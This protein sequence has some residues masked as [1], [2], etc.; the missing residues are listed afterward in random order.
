VERAIAGP[1]GTLR[2]TDAGDGTAI[3]GLHGLTASRRYVLMGSRALERRGHRVILYDARGHGS[4]DPPADARYGY[5]QLAEDLLALLDALDLRDALLVGASMGAHTAVRFALEHPQR[6]AGL[7]LVTPAYDPDRFEQALPRWD[8]LAAAL[9]DGGPDGFIEAYDPGRLAPSW[10]ETVERV[11]AQRLAAHQHL[12]AVAD[13][14]AAVPRSR[15]FDALEDLAAIAA[16]TLVVA[17]RDE[18]DP[19]HPLEL[20]RRYADAIAGAELIVEEPNR[21][22]IAWQGGQLS[23][24]IAALAARAAP[25]GEHEPFS[26]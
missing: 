21:S 2:L 9:R 16:P 10:R 15:P 19:D 13:A 8:R 20:A 12:D 25:R 11:I 23:S 26:R 3:V 1:A 22:P 5:A 17:S 6:V 14:L 4:S 7:A 24:A 18:A